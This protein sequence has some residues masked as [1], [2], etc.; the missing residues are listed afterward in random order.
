MGSHNNSA[1]SPRKMFFLSGHVCLMKKKWSLLR[2]P[3]PL[4]EHCAFSSMKKNRLTINFV[5][6][7]SV[8]TA[9]HGGE[10]SLYRLCE[11]CLLV[12]LRVTAAMETRITRFLKIAFGILLLFLCF[13]SQTE[14]TFKLESFRE[15]SNNNDTSVLKV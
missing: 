10:I 2:F 13:L 3:N 1:W 8:C 11:W 4:Q 5:D 7:Y 14:A 9:I 15:W 12:F 6:V